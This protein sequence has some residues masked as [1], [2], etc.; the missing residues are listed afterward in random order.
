M[1]RTDRWQPGTMENLSA[2]LALDN[3]VRALVA[4]G[5]TAS[6]IKMVD[7]WSD[8]DV[9]VVVKD[10]RVNRFFPSLDWL[11]PLGSLFAYE[12]YP[13]EY[14]HTARVC[15]VDFRRLDVIIADESSMERLQEWPSV[16]FWGKR[17]VLF[18]S[19]TVV[20]AALRYDLAPP[21]R[22][23]KLRRAEHQFDE[24]GNAFWFK[25]VL[26]VSKLV[27]GDRLVAMHLCLD[28]VRDCLV[29]GMMLRER[30]GGD[31]DR[32]MDQVAELRHPYSAE[33]IITSLA[34]SS[35]VYDWL[36]SKW[37]PTY[38]VRGELFRAWLAEARD[39]LRQR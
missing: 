22:E 27:R 1:V 2:I 31:W 20:N 11:E 38:Y 7:G 24:L 3:D 15:L 16:P 19:S 14:K 28:L 36:A 12:L 23:E 17:R 33:D 5:S 4:F 26:A 13:G 30:D 25:G 9:L 32:V 29:L 6:G 39:A 34:Q 21:T 18:S 8:L 10:G 37:S 35:V